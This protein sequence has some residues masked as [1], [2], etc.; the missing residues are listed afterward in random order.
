MGPAQERKPRSPLFLAAIQEELR[1][2][3]EANGAEDRRGGADGAVIRLAERAVVKGVGDV[4]RDAGGEDRERA[5]AGAEAAVN[6]RREHGARD[7]VSDDVRRVRVERERRDCAPGLAGE[8]EARD[9]CA[10]LEPAGVASDGARHEEEGSEREE[11]ER[12][13]RG[14]GEARLLARAAGKSRFSV[15]SRSIEVEAES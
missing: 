12:G 8:D 3:Q 5:A 1:R 13:R 14:G 9:G 2:R 15:S 10:A 11:E 7:G 4:A 6:S